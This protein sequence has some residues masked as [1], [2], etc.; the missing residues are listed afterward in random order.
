MDSSVL[1]EMRGATA[2][3]TLNRPA[4]RNAIDMAMR[5]AL[6]EAVPR[7]RDDSRVR[8]VVITGAG[9]HFCAGADVKL[10]ADAQ[11]R[12]RDVFEGRERIRRFRL[13]MDELMD[14]PK[15]VIAA[16]QGTAVGAGLSL[17]LAADMVLAAPDASLS[18]VFARVGYVPDMGAMYSLP[19]AVGLARAKELVFSGRMIDAQEAQAMGLVQA[20]H[21]NGQLLEEALSLAARFEHAPAGALAIAKQMLNRSFES[22]RRTVFEYEAMA[23]SLCRESAFHQEAVSRFLAKQPPLFDWER[24]DP[25]SKTQDRHD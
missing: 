18:C 20:I 23:Q 10:L 17:A 6:A 4:Q 15:P 12:P 14:L 24:S 3:V 11:G 9:A 2:L 1:L 22:D 25:A 7:L 5:E 21:P 19:R 16:I 13:W 8:A